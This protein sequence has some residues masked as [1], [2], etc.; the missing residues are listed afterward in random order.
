P[1]DVGLFGPLQVA[2][3]KAVEDFFLTTSCGVNRNLYFPL[4]KHARAKADTQKYIQAAFK[5][6]GI[7]PF[8]SGAVL[9][10]LQ[11]PVRFQPPLPQSVLER[12]PYTRHDIRQQTNY[13]LT[14]LK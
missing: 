9:S 10:Q 7:V 11:L 12:T 2:Y 5:V 6:T 8:N 3:R 14:F 4:Y 13:A 1:L